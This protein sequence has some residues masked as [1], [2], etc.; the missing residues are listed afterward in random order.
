MSA[1]V[2]CDEWFDAGDRASIVCKLPIFSLVP[3][4]ARKLLRVSLFSI[5]NPRNRNSAQS[6]FCCS[7]SGC[8]LR[9]VDDTLH[10]TIIY[11]CIPLSILPSYLMS[12]FLQVPHNGI[13]LHYLSSNVQ[14]QTNT[15]TAFTPYLLLH[16][17][18]DA[19]QEESVP[20]DV[21]LD[22]TQTSQALCT[23]LSRYRHNKLVC[24]TLVCHG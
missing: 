16:S 8:L 14:Q 11:T 9:L 7:I 13:S 5:P 23:S 3:H 6:C 19:F 10:D 20:G 24:S 2:V 22:Q 18:L 12:Q 15:M 21:Y 4:G 17:T 1:R